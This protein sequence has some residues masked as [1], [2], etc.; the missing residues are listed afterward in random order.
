M[1][2]ALLTQHERYI[3]RAQSLSSVKVKKSKAVPLHAIHGGTRG[4]RRNSSYSYLTSALDGGEWSATRRGRALPPG[5]EQPVPIGQESGW[6]SEPVW[7][8]RLEEKSSG[9]VGDR[10]P[11]VQSVVSHYVY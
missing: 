10:T 1:T 11:V 8:Q 5:K 7:T 9:S 3:G 2:L 6:A 4:E